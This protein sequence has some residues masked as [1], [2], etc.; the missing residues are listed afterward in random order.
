MATEQ[1]AMVDVAATAAAA[2]AEPPSLQEAFEKFRQERQRE[3]R[4]SRQDTASRHRV[5]GAAHLSTPVEALTA[6]PNSCRLYTGSQMRRQ[7]RA[8]Q[9]L[10]QR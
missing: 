1:A 8:Q 4:L 6:L 7:G 5:S 9:S 2:A 3:R 10:K